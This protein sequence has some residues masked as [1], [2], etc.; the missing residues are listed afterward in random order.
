MSNKRITDLTELTAPTSD[1]VFPVVDIAT[2]TTQK[3][4][5]GNLPVQSAVTTALATKQDTLVSGTNIKTVNSTSILGSGNISI[6]TTSPSGVSG[7]IQFSNGSAFASD[8]ANFFWDNTNKRLGVGTNTPSE[9]GHFYNTALADIYVK[10]QTTQSRTSGIIAQNSTSNWFS[11]TA[12]SAT[13]AYQVFDQTNN[14][15]QLTMFNTGNSQF[16]I[17]NSPMGAKLGIQGSGSTSATTS[18]L[19]QNS[20]GTELFKVQDN[21]SVNFGFAVQSASLTATAN[22]NFGNIFYGNSFWSQNDGGTTIGQQAAPVASAIL[23]IRST[24]R[25]FLPPRMTTTQKNAIASP[26]AGLVLYDSTTNKLCCYNGST[27]NDLF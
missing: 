26:A 23:D 13:N 8:A 3:V 11:G 25:G 20:A 7:A 1:D 2:N 21:G 5:L 6:P 27:W 24:T 16:S 15:L 10:I 22:I 4:Q 19:V 18:L 12:Y 9:I 17:S 14:R